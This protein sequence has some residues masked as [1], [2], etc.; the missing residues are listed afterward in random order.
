MNHSERKLLGQFLRSRR[1]RLSPEAVGLPGGRRRRTPGLRREEV[2]QLAGVS[3]TWYTWIEQG[4]DIRCSGQVL[5]SLARVLQLPP[6]EK[7]YLFTLAGQQPEPSPP[8]TVEAVDPTLQHI[9]DHQG[10]Y[11]A[12]VMDHYWFILAWNRAALRLFGDFEAMLPEE[13]NMVWYTLVRPETRR[14]V[15]DWAERARRLIAEFRAD[16]SPYAADPELTGLLE[17]LK[18]KSPDF[19]R[20]WS[21]HDLEQRDGGRRDFNHPKVG[22]L[23]LTQ[24]TLRLSHQPQIKLVLHVPLPL[25]DSEAK[26]SRL[27]EAV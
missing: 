7:G 22:R 13:R 23:A 24:T 6:H 12:Y 5:E 21:Q 18:A 4:R 2:A 25:F 9:L 15:V 8:Q 11:P 19:A 17:R 3:V 20:W 10:C 1:E 16:C 14:L 26:L 27:S